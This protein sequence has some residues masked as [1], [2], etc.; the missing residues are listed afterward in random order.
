MALAACSRPDPLVVAGANSTEQRILAEIVARQLESSDVP[1]N[2]ASPYPSLATAHQALLVRAAD[3]AVEYTGAAWV[4]ILHRDKPNEFSSLSGLV[5]AAY[6]GLQLKWFDTLGFDNRFVLVVRNAD[7]PAR[8]ISDAARQAPRALAVTPEFPIRADGMQ[9]LMSGYPGLRWASAART[10]DSRA[11][12][13]D[14]GGGRVGMVAGN[15]ADAALD[16]PSFCVLE[17]D[18][19]I[20]LPEEAAIV[21]RFDALA[22]HPQA[23]AAIAALSGR[24][25]REDMRRMIRRVETGSMSVRAVAADFLSPGQ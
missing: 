12:Y 6:A 19:H 2:R 17:D 13:S 10:E 11:L 21:A 15:A 4:G 3:V 9:T 16:D 8:T 22:A 14:L 24:I 18:R 23:E 7:P 1:V 25:S 5:R 20:L